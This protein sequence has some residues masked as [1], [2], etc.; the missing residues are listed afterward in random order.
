M[1]LKKWL[2]VF[3]CSL[4]VCAAQTD[5]SKP[6]EP[7]SIGVFF[8]LEPGTQALKELPKEEFKRHR[9]TGWAS[10]TD[11][12]KVSGPASAFHIT[13]NDKTTFVF[14]ATGE[15]AQKAELYRFTVK[16]DGREYEIGKWKRRDFIPNTGLPLTLAQF[17]SSSYKVTTQAALEPGEYA[18][19]MGS[20]VYTFSVSA[21]SSAS[22][23]ANQPA[24]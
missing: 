14:K 16:G 21:P 11:S 3:I 2:I 24:K 4:A 19:T 6:S 17:G 1:V 13:S 23:A 8:Y 7:E 9:G 18:L 5:T 10:V 20:S 15:L 12:V 22:N